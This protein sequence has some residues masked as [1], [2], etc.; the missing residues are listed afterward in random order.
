MRLIIELP[1]RETELA[2]PPDIAILIIL[3]EQLCLLPGDVANER[4]NRYPLEYYYRQLRH[5]EL[6]GLCDFTR[7]TKLFTSCMYV[8]NV[9]QLRQNLFE[10]ILT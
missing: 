2:I 5:I 9:I 10:V 7:F 6:T 1:L 8:E 3:V 4:L